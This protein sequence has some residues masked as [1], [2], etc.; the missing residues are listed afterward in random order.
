MN[1][2]KVGVKMRLRGL[3][4]LVIGLTL[5]FAC[6]IGGYFT[7]RI[8]SAVNI[9]PIVSQ[10]LEMQQPSVVAE[11]V[12]GAAESAQAKIPE[13]SEK[14]IAA[15]A[16]SP[17]DSDGRININSATK[18]ELMDL[19]GIGSVLAERITDYRKSKG[20]FTKIE[21]IRN[22]SGIGEKRFEAIKDKITV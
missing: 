21:D 4:L 20:L 13:Q 10:Q 19:P 16:G 9:V 11:Q 8:T 3:E 18:S 14:E 15:P 12:S 2:S 6:F 5:A 7:G 22:V 1:R 17:R